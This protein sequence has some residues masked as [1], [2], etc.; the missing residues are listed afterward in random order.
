[1]VMKAV[2]KS[3]KTFEKISIDEKYTDDDTDGFVMVIFPIDTWN[4]VQDMSKKIGIETGE[5][6]SVALEMM[7]DEMKKKECGNE[8]RKN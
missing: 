1:M 5:V 6:I 4:T 7:K 2:S 8:N 3:N